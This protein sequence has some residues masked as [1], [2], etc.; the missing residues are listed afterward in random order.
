M[1]MNDAAAHAMVL[2]H[3]GADLAI[4]VEASTYWF[5]ILTTLHGD[6]AEVEQQGA[7]TTL[8]LFTR[9]GRAKLVL[10]EDNARALI[11]LLAATVD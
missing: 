5:G 1:S 6:A 8:Q 11:G 9:A 2:E 7:L 3:P 10:T 4:T